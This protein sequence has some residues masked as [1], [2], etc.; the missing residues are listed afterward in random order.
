M[1]FKHNFMIFFISL[2]TNGD[3]LLALHNW[4][5]VSW[6]KNLADNAKVRY[7]LKFLLIRY[8]QVH[9]DVSLSGIFP[10]TIKT[11]PCQEL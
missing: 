4:F 9:L 7:F 10:W 2:H 3:K 6:K 11:F 8:L 1:F 5:V